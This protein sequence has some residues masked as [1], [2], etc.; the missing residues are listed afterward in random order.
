MNRAH[1]HRVLG[2][3]G[4]A[5]VASPCFLS[6]DSPG[7]LDS[8]ASSGGAGGAGGNAVTLGSGGIS[9]STTGGQWG[10]SGTPPSVANNCGSR[11]AT[12]HNAPDI[13]LVLDRSTSMSD[14]TKTASGTGSTRYK[15]LVAALNQVLPPTDASINW[16]LMLF[17]HKPGDGCTAGEVDVTPRPQNT[18][19]VAAAYDPKVISPGGS[20]PMAISIKN[21]VR[22]LAAL[23]DAN[24]KYIVLATDGGPDCGSVEGAIAAVHMSSLSGI[25]VFVIS[26]SDEGSPD[27]LN[28]LAVAGGRPLVDPNDPKTQY[29]KANTTE[30][31]VAAMNAIN[32]SVMSCDFKLPSEPPDPDNVLVTYDDGH[33][34]GPSATTWGYT[35]ATRTSI[36]LY[37]NDCSKVLAG[38][39]KSIEI[40]FGCPANCGGQQK[41]QTKRNLSDVLLVLDRSASMNDG[42]S[43]RASA[44]AGTRYKDVVA[45]LN[46]VLPATNSAI[47]WGLELYPHDPGDGCVPGVVDIP[48]KP[49][50]ANAVAAFYDPSVIDPGGFTPTTASMRNAVTALQAL[51][52][53]IPKYI[54]LATDGEPNCDTEAGTASDNAVASVRAASTAGI[55][56]FV[57]SI[58]NEGSPDTLNKMA[59]AGGRP[60]NDPADPK[61]KY[62]KANTTA[63][64]VAVMNAITQQIATCQFALPSTPPVPDN[65]LVVFDDGHRALP[66]ATTWGYTDASCSAITVYGDDCSK[67]MNGTYNG[68]RILYGCPNE[69]QLIP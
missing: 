48:I 69:T 14:G 47:N 43:S 60:A 12:T 11:K 6:C 19:A 68:V 46:Q 32:Q 57:I 45:A 61:T 2:L 44:V 25:P 16:G 24:P 50:N 4:G 15:D 3:L 28:K 66:S 21:A 58:A 27:T 35:D 33:S 29:Y 52:D 5:L 30:K 23:S 63:E 62:Y 54:V 39:Y 64:M 56:V 13:L 38:T 41:N 34:A 55:P 9:T 49:M 17:P 40:L 20:T 37:G 1:R 8:R 18:S 26:L 10:Q 51:K 31:M 65:V 59:E 42:T 22:A 67:L 53:G 36:A 7:Q